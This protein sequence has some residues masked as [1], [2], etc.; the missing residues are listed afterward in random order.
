M[1]AAHEEMDEALPRTYVAAQP[2]LLSAHRLVRKMH[3]GREADMSEESRKTSRKPGFHKLSYEER[4]DFVASWGGLDESR[5]A[6]ILSGGL[7][8]D[9]ADRMIEN[10]V[11]RL[12]LPMG[13]GLNLLV[14]GR[15]RLVLMAIEEP[16][17]V[18]GMSHAAKM[19]R[20]GG[21]VTVQVS[22]P[23]MI[24]QI[25]I[26]DA[27]PDRAVAAL[28]QARAEILHRANEVD[29]ILVRVGGGAR[30]M[31]VRV[32]APSGP[33]DPVGA[34]VVV[35]LLVDVRDAMGA[36]AVNSMAETLAPF[37]EDLTGG[38]VRLRIL[39][40]LAD[41][42][43]LRAEGRVPIASLAGRG[44][45]PQDVARGIVEASVFAERD[46]YRAATH[47]KGI[48]NGIDAVLLA[49]GQDF[50]AVEAGAH[51]YAARSGRYSALATWRIDGDDL[52]GRLEMPMAV[53]TVGGVVKT[54]PAVAAALQVMEVEGASDL[55]ALV[56]AA[57]L[58]QNLAALRALASEGIQRGHMKLHARNLAVAAGAGPDQVG[59]VVDWMVGHGKVTASGAAEALEVISGS[60]G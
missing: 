37:I 14:N 47:N 35:H 57:G 32:L 1:F 31:E 15:E 4:L 28:E 24:A 29:P 22:E 45:D 5:R 20:D 7:E 49:T 59:A 10:V 39:S 6:A 21:G 19:L 3:E 34:M 51:A 26:L 12:G 58:A 50:R 53:G 33:S 30:D 52:V 54:H 43:L 23:V 18:A 25:Q 60:T 48:M 2:A 13:V 16:S 46:P 42:R 44:T 17:V 40:N 9:A 41:R 8:L 38:R 36:N 56:G 11:G 55:A 27:D